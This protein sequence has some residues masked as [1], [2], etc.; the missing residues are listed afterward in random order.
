MLMQV[1]HDC[2]CDNIL[3]EASKDWLILERITEVA[4][5]DLGLPRAT[6]N[7]AKYSGACAWSDVVNR[8][9]A[10]ARCQFKNQLPL[11]SHQLRH[12]EMKHPGSCLARGWVIYG[13]ADRERPRSVLS[14]QFIIRHCPKGVTL[15]SKFGRKATRAATCGV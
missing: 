3:S 11:C 14:E 9:C 6:V 8:P 13:P 15:A 1:F 7:L 5:T 12:P 2:T 4:N 10:S